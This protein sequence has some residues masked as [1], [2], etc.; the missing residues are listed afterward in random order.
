MQK[1]VS[2]QASGIAKESRSS[3]T[4]KLDYEVQITGSEQVVGIE[5]E[6]KKENGEVGI[7]T[8]QI[9][10]GILELM[11]Q[12]EALLTRLSLFS[13]QNKMSFFSLFAV[14]SF[15]LVFTIHYV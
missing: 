13:C 14:K 9:V 5:K 4:R 2:E 8:H 6:S 15:F 1:T 3:V 12:W 7:I 10:K 11:M